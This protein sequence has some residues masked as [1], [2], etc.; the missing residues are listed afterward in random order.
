MLAEERRARILDIL[1]EKGSVSVSQLYHRLKVSRETIRRDIT[2]LD[3]ENKLRKTHGGALALD[4]EEPAFAERMSV[5]I[6]GKRTIGRLAAGLVP[7]G[8]SLL[9]DAGTSTLCLAE[10]LMAHR[11]LTVLTNDLQIAT[12][13]AGRNDNR[14]LLLGG[15][16]NAAEGLTLGRDTTN[17]L[18]HYFADFAFVGAGALSAHP[19]LTDY[20]REAVEIRHQMIIQARTPVLLAD[21]TKFG[22]TAPVLVDGLDKIRYLVAD[23]MP[24]ADLAG[25]LRDLGMEI[26]TPQNE[27]G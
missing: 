10:C 27:G 19:W 5:N 26:V 12:R 24:P 9:V 16:L 4:R 15:E 18:A 11:R 21:S 23:V 1:A 13:L 14:V 6:E 3:Q 22:R 20:S 17:M 25:A 8:A 2:R 7:D